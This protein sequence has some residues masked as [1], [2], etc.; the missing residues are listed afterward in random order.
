MPCNKF[1]SAYK[2]DK[3]MV[4]NGSYTGEKNPNGYPLIKVQY[5]WKICNKNK[6]ET[7]VLNSLKT[8]AVLNHEKQSIMNVAG[9]MNAGRTDGISP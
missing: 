4:Q 3:Q 5:E 8:A 7:V 2:I 9:R 1:Q 6:N